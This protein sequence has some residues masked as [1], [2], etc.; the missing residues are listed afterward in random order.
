M[1]VRASCSSLGNLRVETGDRVTGV[2]E[3]PFLDQ[4]L[5]EHAVVAGGDLDLLAAAADAA[6]RGAGGG[7]G[8]PRPL[9]GADGAW[10]GGDHDPPV[11]GVLGLGATA[12]GGDQ[13]TGPVQVGWAGHGEHLDPGA[14][15]LA[16][17]QP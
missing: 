6:N 1:L 4:P 17:G 3:V 14:L 12:L 13:L 11:G 10:E 2:D 16:L 15:P 5:G 7:P 9:G 8:G